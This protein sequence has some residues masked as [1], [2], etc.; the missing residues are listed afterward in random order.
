M[1]VN[2]PKF[3]WNTATLAD[4]FEIFQQHMEIHFELNGVEKKMQVPTILLATGIEGTRRFNS[5]N[6]STAEKK[7]PGK[8]FKRFID[9]MKPPQNPRI[10]RL[11]LSRLAMDEAEAVDVFVNRC[12]RL[13]QKC[14]FDSDKERD[15]RVVELLIATTH[16]PDLRKELLANGMEMTLDEAVEIARTHEA[17]MD[18]EQDMKRTSEVVQINALRAGKCT[19]CGRKHKPGKRHC[20]AGDETCDNCGKEGHWAVVCR[21]PKKKKQKTVGAVE[22]YDIE[23][24][25]DTD[26][27]LVSDVFFDVITI[28]DSDMSKNKAEVTLDVQGS[29]DPLTL[30]ADTGAQANALPYHIFQDRFPEKTDNLGRP[31]KGSVTPTSRRLASYNGSPIKCA[32]TI[33]LPVRFRQTGWEKVRFYVVDVSGPAILGLETCKRLNVLTMNVSMD[34][35]PTPAESMKAAPDVSPVRVE[36]MELQSGQVIQVQNPIT[37]DWQTATLEEHRGTLVYTISH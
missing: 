7:D 15:G 19:Y 23:G 5:W 28:S 18:Q 4:D 33:D 2:Y 30:K 6:L 21:A 35:G 10:N 34:N 12:Q 24:V 32:G 16:L 9:Q 14:E 36:C 8:V 17:A 37:G 11:Q 20:P 29:T 25:G 1:A 26:D 27:E 3:N 22:A 13:A 31:K